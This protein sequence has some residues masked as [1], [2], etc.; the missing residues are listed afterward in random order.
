MRLR[1]RE[2]PSS[3]PKLER[4]EIVF[5]LFQTDAAMLQNIQCGL[6]P[7]KFNS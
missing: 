1:Y 7:E 4:L 2:F 6:T 5:L 3:F